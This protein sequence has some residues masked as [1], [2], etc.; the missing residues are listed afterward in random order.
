MYIY[1]L[2]ALIARKFDHYR[3]EMNLPW[4]GIPSINKLKSPSGLNN[5]T[6]Y[7]MENVQLKYKFLCTYMLLII[8]NWDCYLE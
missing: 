7:L 4:V 6:H 8:S 5:L 2:I 3:K 1:S